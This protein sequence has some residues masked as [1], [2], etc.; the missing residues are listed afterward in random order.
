M[1]GLSIHLLAALPSCHALIPSFVPSLSSRHMIQTHHVS[2]IATFSTSKVNGD[3]EILSLLEMDASDDDEETLLQ[4]KFLSEELTEIE[5]EDEQDEET[6]QDNAFMLEAINMARSSGGERSSSGPFPKPIAGAVLVAKDG[7]ILGKGRSNYA[8]HA[9]EFAF[10]EAGINATP[11]REWCVAWPSDSKLRRDFS[12]STL[13]VTL[14]PSNERQ[15]EEKPPIT[16]LIQMAGIPRLVIGCQDPIP[17]NAAEG[18][19]RLH[20]AG[21]SVTM[22]I[23]QEECMDLIKGYT[24]LCNTKL[25][26]LARQHMKRF[27]RVSYVYIVVESELCLQFCS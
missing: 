12:E 18:A 22:G 3:D 15:G 11:L 8:G 10:K 24:A 1:R 5:D 26:R 2:R 25:Q 4:T 19:G 23:R 16:Q 6:K 14:E 27:G 21:V 9:I 13:Y 7:R 17:E 20:A